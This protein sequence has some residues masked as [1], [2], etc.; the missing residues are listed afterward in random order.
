MAAVFGRTVGNMH[1]SV[2]WRNRANRTCNS[3]RNAELSNAF[4]LSHSPD[5]SQGDWQ[6]GG[7]VRLELE[8]AV[9]I[10]E[11]F[12]NFRDLV[13]LSD[14]DL[15]RPSIGMAR[16]VRSHRNRSA[17]ASMRTKAHDDADK[18]VGPMCRIGG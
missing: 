18:G 11:R 12:V 4:S 9:R 3:R 14:D 7:V 16:G 10:S 1:R 8:Y 2:G 6:G 15:A 17:A 5:N 13:L